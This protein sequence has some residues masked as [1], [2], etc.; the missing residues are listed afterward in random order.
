MVAAVLFAGKAWS[1][2]ERWLR[3]CMDMRWPLCYSSFGK[4][5]KRLA[6][7]KAHWRF[8]GW[9]SLWGCSSLIH[10]K[11][12]SHHFFYK[13]QALVTN[14][15]DEAKRN[16]W[17]FSLKMASYMCLESGRHCKTACLEREERPRHLV[18][19]FASLVKYIKKR[20]MREIGRA[21]SLLR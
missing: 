14:F 2:S 7:L 16:L 10:L 9:R 8:E 20:E 13:L 17:Y 15:A 5:K 6:Q 3:V 21:I 19:V 4:D 11:A 12:S 1:T 18:S